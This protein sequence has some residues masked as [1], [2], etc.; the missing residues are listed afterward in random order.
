MT[1]KFAKMAIL[2]LLLSLAPAVPVSSQTAASSQIMLL[3]KAPDGSA[4]ANARVSVYKVPFDH[5]ESYSLRQL[6]LGSADA[7]GSFTFGFSDAINQPEINAIVVAVNPSRRWMVW[8]F[9][10]LPTSTDGT[11]ASFTQTANVDVPTALPGADSASLDRLVS[12]S[13]DGCV[14]EADSLGVDPTI[15]ETEAD[16]DDSDDSYVAGWSPT[17]DGCVTGGDTATTTTTT[18][19]ASSESLT[20]SD[21]TVTDSDGSRE[22]IGEQAR[23]VKVADHHVAKAFKSTFTLSEGK[24]TR[25]QVGIKVGE[26]PWEAG[27]M[28]LESASRSHSRT[29]RLEHPLHRT[30]YAK[31]VFYKWKYISCITYY[32]CF[33]VRSWE[34]HHWTGGLRRSSFIGSCAF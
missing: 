15:A 31:Y 32:Y 21:G 17:L 8:N 4:L 18:S 10:I 9:Q 22:K 25:T 28:T 27:E 3:L 33:W 26:G 12:W 20:N 29:K 1:P 5:G 34:P 23:W 6:A 2:S 19:G 24:A 13:S 11:I 7:S 30:R 14:V 16:P